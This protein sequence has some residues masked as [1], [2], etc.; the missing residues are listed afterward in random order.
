VVASCRFAIVGRA[1]GRTSTIREENVA[2]RRCSWLVIIGLLLPTAVPA[3]II[4]VPADESTIQ[5]GIDTAVDGDTVLVADGL[6]TGP[7]NRD[8][9]S[10]GKTILVTSENG[11]EATIIDC[12]GTSVE[13]HRAFHFHKRERPQSIVRGLTIRGGYF[14]WEY[15]GAILC[16]HASPTITECIFEGNVAYHGGAIYCADSSA[17]RILNSLFVDNTALGT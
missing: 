17:V 13:P 9:D 15:G 7:G 5:A 12:G 16:E 8:I 10:G 11:A 6:Y 3:T 1:V 4:H 2:T 14:P